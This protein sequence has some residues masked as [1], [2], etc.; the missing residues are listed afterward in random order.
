V[1]VTTIIPGP[2]IFCVVEHLTGDINCWCH[3]A[4]LQV[5][6]ACDA[7]W[8]RSCATCKDKGLVPQ[9]DPDLPYILVHH[10]QRFKERI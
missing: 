3:P 9:Y 5:C 8:P 4:I 6:P 10:V 7:A 2:Q 1:G